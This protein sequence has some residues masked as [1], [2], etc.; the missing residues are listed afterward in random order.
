M[1]KYLSASKFTSKHFHLLF[2]MPVF[3]FASWA[4]RVSSPAAFMSFCPCLFVGS[5][6][7]I[8]EQHSGRAFPRGGPE[9]TL[10]PSSGGQEKRVSGEVREAYCQK[11]VNTRHGAKEA[12]ERHSSSLLMGTKRNREEESTD[13]ALGEGGALSSLVR[14]GVHNAKEPDKQTGFV[15]DRH[16][17]NEKGIRSLRRDRTRNCRKI[18]LGASKD[19]DVDTDR[20]LPKGNSV[21]ML[22]VE[23]LCY[24]W[25]PRWIKLAVGALASF[26]GRRCDVGLREHVQMLYVIEGGTHLRAHNGQV[27]TYTDG[28]WNTYEGMISEGTM[29]R[30]STYL[31]R[32]DGLLR[33]MAARSGIKREEKAL[34]DS[35]SRVLTTPGGPGGSSTERALHYFEELRIEF[36]EPKGAGTT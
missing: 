25:G 29:A 32:L 7:L 22:L 2:R 19:E 17:G 1:E 35:I 33:A 28:S 11:K 4:G 5:V 6:Q 14:A 3:V 21:R 30:R 34:I 26:R 24:F 9:A 23:R 10:T 27:F 8:L 18:F 12:W 36:G 20:I 15:G 16:A 13:A 31:L